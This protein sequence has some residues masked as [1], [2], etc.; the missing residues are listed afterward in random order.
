V[1]IKLR[2]FNF[3]HPLIH[4]K[5]QLPSKKNICCLK[6]VFKRAGCKRLK[7]ENFINAV[8]DNTALIS[9]LAFSGLN[10]QHFHQLQKGD[11]ILFINLRSVDYLKDL[12]HI[13]TAKE[14]LD[15][16]N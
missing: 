1:K 2:A 15:N 6:N 8:V 4:K 10:K 7:K 12:Y 3:N 5:H 9:S 11:L 14:F 16:N 13:K